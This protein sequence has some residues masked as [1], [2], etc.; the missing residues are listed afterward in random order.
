MLDGGGLEAE[1]ELDLLVEASAEERGVLGAVGKFG[2]GVG[3][4]DALEEDA[5]L[6]F[7]DALGGRLGVGGL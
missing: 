3:D 5:V 1:V 6:G 4:L 2:A 7:G